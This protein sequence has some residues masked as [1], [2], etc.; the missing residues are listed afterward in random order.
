M[1]ERKACVGESWKDEC[2]YDYRWEIMLIFQSSPKCGDCG[3]ALAGVPALRP[4]KCEHR[5]LEQAAQSDN[6]RYPLQATEDRQPSLRWI[7]LRYLRP[8][9]VSSFTSVS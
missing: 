7:V 2:A 6:R 9:A 4:R 1:E 5:H 3:D 8:S